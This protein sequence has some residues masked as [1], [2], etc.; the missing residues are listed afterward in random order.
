MNR[1]VTFVAASLCAA[2]AVS[3]ACFAAEGT[4]V[5]F[6]LGRTGA[7]GQVQLTL[8]R[9][10]PGNRHSWSQS[11]AITDLNGLSQQQLAAPRPTPARFA[12][13]RPAGR[14]DCSGSVR[15]YKGSGRCGFRPDAGFNAMLE[16][17]GIGRP[18]IDQSANLAMANVQP[19]LFDALATAGYPRPTIEQA[20]SLGVFDVNPAYVREL[21]QA[22]YRLSSVNDLTTFKIHRVNPDLIRAYR[23]LGYR[24]LR[25]SDLVTMSIHQVTPD[26]I[27]GFASVGYRDLPVSKLVQ[28][29]IFNVTPR[30]VTALQSRIGERPTADEV[31]SAKLV[32]FQPRRRQR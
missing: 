25:A 5:D 31:V 28:L 2:L 4:P 22:G 16:R 21:A 23:S 30:D 14:F 18:S 1:A 3:S 8:E 29:R 20:V 11:V 10:R 6:R 32:G 7:S 19:A 13:I 12:L 17:R 26:F 15:S 24:Q 9:N 27:R